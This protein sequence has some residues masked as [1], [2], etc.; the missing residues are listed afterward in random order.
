MVL[1]LFVKQITKLAKWYMSYI[2]GSR[3]TEGS[4]LR[5]H[6]S[7]PGNAS[8]RASPARLAHLSRGI[9]NATPSVHPSLLH[10]NFQTVDCY[11]C[12]ENALSYLITQTSVYLSFPSLILHFLLRSHKFINIQIWEEGSVML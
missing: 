2:L 4:V 3:A 9:P 12:F 1:P 7:S 6:T 8:P 11:Q 10:C 5:A